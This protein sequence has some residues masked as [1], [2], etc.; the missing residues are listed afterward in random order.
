MLLRGDIYHENQLLLKDTTFYLIWYSKFGTKIREFKM[1]RLKYL[2]TL[3][4]IIY[5]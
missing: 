1:P 2:F 4:D 5:S 3:L